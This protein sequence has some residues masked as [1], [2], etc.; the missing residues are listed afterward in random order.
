M[1]VRRVAVSQIA[2]KGALPRKRKSGA[3]RAAS[4]IPNAREIHSAIRH[5]QV[6]KVSVRTVRRDLHETLGPRK[7]VVRTARHAARM[8]EERAIWSEHEKK[9][10]KK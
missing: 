3:I 1:I 9:L 10:Q 8:R 4:L 6:G 2:A 5:T 7:D